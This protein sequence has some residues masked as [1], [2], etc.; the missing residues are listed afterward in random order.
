MLIAL[1]SELPPPRPTSPTFSS[2]SV[3]LSLFYLSLSVSLSFT[4]LSC[5]FLFISICGQIL[6]TYTL[7]VLSLQPPLPLVS[8]IPPLRKHRFGSGY[9][10]GSNILKITDPI[11]D[12]IVFNKASL[13]VV[14][15]CNHIICYVIICIFYFRM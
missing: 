6:N 3:S 14:H 11:P 1:K 9:E 7:E 12:N 5:F 10:R 13:T 4:F 2:V 8:W 15:L